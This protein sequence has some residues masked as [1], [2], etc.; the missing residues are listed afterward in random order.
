MIVYFFVQSPME[1][2]PALVIKI[3]TRRCILGEASGNGINSSTLILTI[4]FQA[5]LG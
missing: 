4:I 1:K 2:T 3:R 5:Q